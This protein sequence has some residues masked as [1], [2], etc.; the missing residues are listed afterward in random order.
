[1]GIVVAEPL[2]REEC[3]AKLLFDHG[4]LLPALTWA[5]AHFQV[6]LI[7][8]SRAVTVA[9]VGIF[10]TVLGGVLL[11]R[12]ATY[13]ESPRPEPMLPWLWRDLPAKVILL[14]GA[15]LALVAVKG[16]GEFLWLGFVATPTWMVYMLRYASQTM[17]YSPAAGRWTTWEKCQEAERRDS[18]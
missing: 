9:A 2:M 12:R 3:V 16:T 15:V 8:G 4:L 6:P 11:L 14:V 18:S 5:P 13:S 17:F 1:M 10:A 7:Y